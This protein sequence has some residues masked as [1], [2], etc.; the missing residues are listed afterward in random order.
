VTAGLA[1]RAVLG[2]QTP[3][4]SWMPVGEWDYTTAERCIAWA[5]DVLGLHL[6]DWQVYLLRQM[7]ATRDTGKWVCRQHGTVCSRQNGK[8]L[9]LLIRCLFGLIELD[10]QKITY[11]VH[12]GDTARD[13]HALACSLLIDPD[14]D[15]PR[16]GIPPHQTYNSA[17]RESINFENGRAL[18]IKTRTSKT[19][20]GVGKVDVL[21]YDEAQELDA[22]ELDAVGPSQGARSMTG[23]PQTFYAGSAG[24][25]QSAAFA[26]QRRRALA[27]TADGMGFAEWSIDD[28]AYWAADT[29]EREAM[30]GDHALWAMANPT[31][32]VVRPDGSGGISTDFLADQLEQLSPGGFAREHLGVGTWPKDD[33]HDWVIPRLDWN[34]QADPERDVT[35]V[36]LVLALSASKS[37]R[38]AFSIAAVTGT[39][40]ECHGWLEAQ[41][42]GSAWVIPDILRL[43]RDNKVSAVLLDDAGPASP[44]ADELAQA[45]KD[46]GV[47]LHL[48]SGRDAAQAIVALSDAVTADPASFTHRGQVEVDA[49][50]A[51]AK[52]KTLG[53]GLWV[54]DRLHSETDVAPLEAL[55]IARHGWVLYG[56]ADSDSWGFF[57]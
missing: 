33:G 15:R 43:I 8:S 37:A 26:R 32:H 11:S 7:C 28:D 4:L 47:T 39:A 51:G 19:G 40:D 41:G 3:R 56:Q 21:V 23:N 53:D 49:A 16:P 54:Y 2:V 45:L 14:T 22:D 52:T 29:F 24:N 34:A 46:T 13:L 38:R 44:L 35:G 17:G 36:P 50:L 6:D 5:R 18:R 55:S 1:E 31:F 9:V 10:D 25:F 20:R 42:T 12:H 30:V 57:E 27:G 48:V